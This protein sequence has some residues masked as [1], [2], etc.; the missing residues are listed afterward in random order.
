MIQENDIVAFAL[1]EFQSVGAIHRRV[2]LNLGILQEARKH[3]QVHLHVVNHQDFSLGR[4][5]PFVRRIHH[6][7]VL[8]IK[9]FE[10][11]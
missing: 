7:H 9:L 3:L 6:V 8:L 11:T 5:E 1:N 2:D 4:L 10:I